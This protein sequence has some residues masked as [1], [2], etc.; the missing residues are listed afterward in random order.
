MKDMRRQRKREG[1]LTDPVCGMRL[2]PYEVT[3]TAHYHGKVY[4]FCSHIC[5]HMFEEDPRKY[6][7][8]GLYS[9]A[10]SGEGERDERDK[11][12]IHS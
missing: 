4:Y 1:R 3:A 9:S 11:P 8:Q 5:R 7:K 2:H 10:V 6:S 12:G